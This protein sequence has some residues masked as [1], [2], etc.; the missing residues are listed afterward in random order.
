MHDA[1]SCKMN[2][3]SR[4]LYHPDTQ[5]HAHLYQSRVDGVGG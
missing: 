3:L 5:P 2:V 1:L 4:Y